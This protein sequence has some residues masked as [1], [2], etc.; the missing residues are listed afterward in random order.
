MTMFP[1]KWRKGQSEDRGGG[2]E[3]EIETG[4][5]SAAERPRGLMLAVLLLMP[6][7]QSLLPQVLGDNPGVFITDSSCCLIQFV[8]LVLAT[9]KA[10]II[11]QHGIY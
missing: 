9:K 10:L 6:L 3:P 7:I 1:I 5:E 8:C 11:H 4:W 2:R